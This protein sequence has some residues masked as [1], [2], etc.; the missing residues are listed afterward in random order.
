M[1]LSTMYFDKQREAVSEKR[2]PLQAPSAHPHARRSRCV[3]PQAT[4]QRRLEPA[5]VS[6]G[7]SVTRQ[8]EMVNKKEMPQ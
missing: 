4:G 7:G 1:P 5:G 6:A 8:I 2:S 3:S